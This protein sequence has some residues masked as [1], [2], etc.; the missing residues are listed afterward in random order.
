[1]ENNPFYK[2]AFN[3][4][5]LIGNDINVYKTLCQPFWH[6]NRKCHLKGFFT[7]TPCGADM[8]TC[9]ICRKSGEQCV[10]V[11]EDV[12]DCCDMLEI[13]IDPDFT[14]EAGAKTYYDS[15]MFV[16]KELVPDYKVPDD[17]GYVDV[18]ENCFT[19]FS[20]GCKHAVNGCTEDVDYAKLFMVDDVVYIKGIPD[21][22][23]ALKGK[24]VCMCGGGKDG[25]DDPNNYCKGASYPYIHGRSKK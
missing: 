17:K 3:P 15:S 2:K 25:C 6:R 7:D 9:P 24:F 11:T 1:M 5:I 23:A 14:Y 16:P 19:V 21:K 10:E 13:E 22:E 18:C 12:K 8:T 4:K 20:P